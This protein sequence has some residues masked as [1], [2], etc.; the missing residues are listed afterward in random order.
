MRHSSSSST[1]CKVV[2][3]EKEVMKKK[4]ERDMTTNCK[5]ISF[6]SVGPALQ[7]LG[8]FFFGYTTWCMRTTRSFSSSPFFVGLKSQISV[9][10]LPNGNLRKNTEERIF[11]NGVWWWNLPS[12]LDSRSSFNAFYSLGPSFFLVV[13]KSRYALLQRLLLRQRPKPL[14]PQEVTALQA[15]RGRPK[16]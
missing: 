2:K 6:C 14:L 10:P 5:I 3:K 1:I 8:T 13:L 4:K 15:H 9:P 11:E 12:E 16:T 7:S